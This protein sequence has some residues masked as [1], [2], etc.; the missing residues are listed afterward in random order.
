MMFL[1]LGPKIVQHVAVAKSRS[2]ETVFSIVAASSTLDYLTMA[3]LADDVAAVIRERNE[4]AATLVGH[5]F[6]NRV[7]RMTTTEYQEV[8]ERIALLCCGG[9]YSR[10]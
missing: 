4:G 7:A 9:Q 3:D 8:A 10:V 1:D 2:K 6:G 5:A